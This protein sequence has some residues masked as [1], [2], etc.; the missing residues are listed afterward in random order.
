M[1]SI[2]NLPID[3]LK[4]FVNKVGFTVSDARIQTLSTAWEDLVCS[5]SSFSTHSL[6]SGCVS[7]IIRNPKVFLSNLK[8][9]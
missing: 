6:K 9:A 2:F 3:L 7:H 4:N 8:N 5:I 1:R